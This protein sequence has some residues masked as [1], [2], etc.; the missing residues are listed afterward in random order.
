MSL[1]AHARSLV[2]RLFSD[3]IKIDCNLQSFET[4]LMPLAETYLLGRYG[5]MNIGLESLRKTTEYFDFMQAF[6]DELEIRYSRALRESASQYLPVRSSL[7]TPEQIP[8]GEM[9]HN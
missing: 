1:E 8:A 3:D 2:D 7:R 9:K 4:R 5:D 6:N